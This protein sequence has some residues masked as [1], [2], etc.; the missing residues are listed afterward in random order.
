MPAE[1]PPG[2]RAR[3]RPGRWVPGLLSHGSA[4]PARGTP[5]GSPAPPGR[6]FQARGSCPVLEIPEVVLRPG[7][8]HRAGRGDSNRDYLS[9]HPAAPFFK[10][11]ASEWSSGIRSPEWARPGFRR[12]GGQFNQ[13]VSGRSWPGQ[14]QFGAPHPP[15]LARPRAGGAGLGTEKN[16]DQSKRKGRQGIGT[17]LEQTCPLEG[18]AAVSRPVSI[19]KGSV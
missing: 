2:T 11:K 7:R 1:R 3:C 12:P 5:D 15:T 10:R 4:S 17:L 19:D 13:S 16:S 14:E 8:G 9:R 6:A 18:G